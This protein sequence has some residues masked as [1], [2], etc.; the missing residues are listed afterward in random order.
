MVL[1]ASWTPLPISIIQFGCWGNTRCD[2][3]G[4]NAR[5]QQC[6]GRPSGP[7]FL[8]HLHP[9]LPRAPFFSPSSFTLFF[10]IL[11]EPRQD[12][13][14]KLKEEEGARWGE[15]EPTDR[16]T[17]TTAAAGRTDSRQGGSGHQRLLGFV[18]GTHG[19][20]TVT[21]PKFPQQ[22]GTY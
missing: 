21:P 5:L 22:G 20:R 17:A 8:P 7:G 11:E 4:R 15:P 2:Q 1:C 10:L 6:L 12:E 9:R 3:G 16:P 19:V 13:L 18:T 14:S